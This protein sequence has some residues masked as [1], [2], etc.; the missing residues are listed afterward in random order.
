SGAKMH[1]TGLH[2]AKPKSGTSGTGSSRTSATQRASSAQQVTRLASTQ[3]A[4]PLLQANGFE[5]DSEWA[6]YVESEGSF[7]QIVAPSDVNIAV[8]PSDI[9]E[10]TNSTAYFFYRNGGV[11]TSFDLS[12][13]GGGYCFLAP[14]LPSGW[15]VSDPRLIYDAA[16]DR[17]V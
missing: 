3:G 13:S 10:V 7:R 16:N 9:G 2:A 17:W 5:G 1:S 11:H 8:G 6:N 15:V 12:C 4:D 14:S